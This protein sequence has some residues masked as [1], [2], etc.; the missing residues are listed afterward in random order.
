MP[1]DILTT[2]FP[3]S[4]LEAGVSG[5][6]LDD[7]LPPDRHIWQVSE[8][9]QELQFSLE[10][11]FPLLWV[12]GEI[13]NC[14]TPVSGHTYFTLKDEKAQIRAVLFKSS[15]GRQRLPVRDGQRVICV[16][17]TNLY[18]GRGDLQLVVDALLP[19][20]DG[21]LRLALEQLKEKLAREGLFSAEH[22][23]PLPLLPGRVFVI[24]S[25]TGAALHDFLRTALAR[26]PGARLVV[27]PVKVQGETA[28]AEIIGALRT[29]Q[30]VSAGQDAVLLAR[31]GGSLE[32]L[33]AF[34]DE[35]LA[36]EIFNCVPAVISAVG[37][38]T[39]FTICDFVADQR[40]ATPT[41]AAQ[42]LFPNRDE[43]AARIAGLAV[44]LTRTMRHR[45]DLASR[46]AGYL[47]HRMPD[48]RK[49]AIG[50]RLRRNDLHARLHRAMENA[51]D[52]KRGNCLALGK[53][54]SARI[55]PMQ[56]AIGRSRSL[57][58]LRRLLQ[59]G[60]SVLGC[61]R[62][63]LASLSNSLDS[64][65]PLGVLARGYSLVHKISD[66]SLVKDSR[67]VAVGD[68]LLLRPNRGVIVCGV[69]AADDEQEKAL[70]GLDDLTS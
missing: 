46:H 37:H 43:L 69:L 27:C 59:D 13:S 38:E 5:Q 18:A 40:A 52:R 8:L 65:S 33:R 9:L 14:R 32:D 45:M 34:N 24:T 25:P 56:L 15:A 50:Q 70:A 31:G 51:A 2:L 22:K 66:G 10:E 41:A 35:A 7:G 64:L 61:K 39:D 49:R 11:K 6:D 53:R 29:V 57:E 42:I 54:L 1:D 30:K 19:R 62:S 60:A 67:Q 17:R 4:A 23:R 3:R 12:E 44:R 63:R 36:R 20:G 21:A 28:P 58:L 16:G 48:P 26:Y 47:A 68:R 55:P